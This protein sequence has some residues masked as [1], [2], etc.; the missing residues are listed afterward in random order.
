VCLFNQLC[1]NFPLAY[2]GWKYTDVSSKMST[3]PDDIPTF[4]AFLK[5]MAVIA[6]VE[7]IG[8]YYGHR[9]FHQPFFCTSPLTHNRTM[10][11]SSTPSL[12]SLRSP[13]SLRSLRSH[14][15]KRFHKM[16]HEWTA[17]VSFVAIYAD[18]LEHIVSNLGP[19]M[20][21][22]YICGA[23]GVVY[24]FWLWLAVAVTIQVHSGYH[25]P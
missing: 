4:N 9:L 20:M 25:F 22:P 18:P 14:T 7:E 17:S 24:W 10:P 19:V 1:I 6:I 15:D 12:L 3:H 16:H 8:F 13:S 2:V 11:N 23:H 21:G 5:M